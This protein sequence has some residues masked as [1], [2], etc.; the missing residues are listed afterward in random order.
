MKI[1][2]KSLVIAMALL[3]QPCPGQEDHSFPLALLDGKTEFETALRD[4]ADGNVG[5]AFKTPR[6]FDGP[7]TWLVAWEEEKPD[8]SPWRVI[9]EDG[10]VFGFFQAFSVNLS[11]YPDLAQ[12]Y[13]KAKSLQRIRIAREKLDESRHYEATLK[14]AARSGRPLGIRINAASDG[15]GARPGEPARELA[16]PNGWIPSPLVMELLEKIRALK[17]D[18]AAFAFLEAQFAK[19]AAQPPEFNALFNRVWDEA[20]FGTGYVDPTWGSMLNDAAFSACYRAGY[21]TQ[22]FSIT[23]NLCTRLEGSGRFGRL[24]EIHAILGEVSRLGGMNL[25]ISSYPDLGPAI[26]ALPS[27]RHREMPYTISFPTRLAGG[28]AAITQPDEFSP[29][30]G[31]YLSYGWHTILRGQWREGLEWTVQAL[32]RSSDEN[33]GPI[34]ERAGDWY[35]ATMNI[36]EILA[37]RGFREEALAMTEAAIAAPYGRNYRGRAKISLALKHLDQLREAGRPDPEMI[38]KLRGLVAQIEDHLHFGKAEHWHAKTVLAKALFHEGLQQEGEQLLETIIAEGSLSGREHRLD[39]WI[40]IGRTEGIEAELIAMLKLVRENGHKIYEVDLYESYA[41]FLE[42]AG[43]FQEAL[44]MRRE[45]IRLCRDFDVFDRLPTQLAKLALLL[46]TLGDDKGS[47]QAADGAL[48]LLRRQGLPDSTKEKAGSILAKRKPAADAIAPLKRPR[49]EVDLQPQESVV[50]P[51][52][53][54]A[55]T[56]YLTLANPG[57]VEQR[58]R[59]VISGAPLGI[60]ENRETDDIEILLGGETAADGQ[61]IDLTLKPATYRLISVSSGPDPAGESE[62][63]LAWIGAN[64]SASVVRIGE[65]E[66][67]VAGAILQAGVYQSNPFY[68]TPIHLSYVA[69]DGSA[70]SPPIRFL[71]SQT[72]RVEIY[73]LDGTPLAID[74]QGNGSLSNPGD[75]LFAK[76]DGAGNLLLPIVGGRSA[77]QVIVY[78]FSPISDEGL[79]LNVEVFGGGKWSLHSSNRIAPRISG[80]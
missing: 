35:A 11:N 31:L 64:P 21:Y 39:H 24:G 75:Q 79:Q 15:V 68:G 65:P 72:A 55:W 38:P 77:L 8:A 69:K 47:E 70:A 53:G 63:K 51:V 28:G 67:G 13:P 22:A 80:R 9:A 71:A 14:V 7:V 23:N 34:K 19:K 4:T 37:Y 6:L 25:D 20:Q 26:E 27:V 60:S 57:S 12:R 43:R 2:S 18:A 50:V 45:A 74:G 76:S 40:S 54:A 58:G 56:T 10:T 36:S 59:L 73:Q 62:L 33:G 44:L 29:L 42:N 3:A 66:S 1:P 78:P 30:A 49:P 46:Q 61:G 16:I 48:A 41:D 5:F 32:D 17:G 52:D